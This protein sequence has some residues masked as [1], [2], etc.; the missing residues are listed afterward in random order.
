LLPPDIFK[1]LAPKPG[2]PN[3]AIPKRD[4]KAT[5]RLLDLSNFYISPLQ[6]PWLWRNPRGQDL[7]A[8][9]Q[10]TVQLP[11]VPIPFDVRGLIQLG[12]SNLFAPFPKR[13]DGIPVRQKCQR[14]HFLHGAIYADPPGTEVGRYE[15]RFT[16]GIRVAIPIIYGRDVLAWDQAPTSSAPEPHLAWK[17]GG[18]SPQRTHH[19]YHEEWSNP[20]PNMEIASLDFVSTMSEAG[21]FLIAITLDP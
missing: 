21:P 19:L 3:G 13:V 1:E 15:V 8:L 17:G 14:L 12:G 10:G 20:H 7:S 11:S 6:S 4:P 18:A 16:N 9:P 2:L 5:P